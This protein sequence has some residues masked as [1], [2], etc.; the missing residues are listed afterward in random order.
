MQSWLPPNCELVAK[1]SSSPKRRTAVGIVNRE[2]GKKSRN[3][4]M[5]RHFQ[6]EPNKRTDTL[7][8]LE[9]W[10]DNVLLERG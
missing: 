10:S 5:L 8:L 3:A 1:H 9:K 4:V 6:M 7:I 2:N